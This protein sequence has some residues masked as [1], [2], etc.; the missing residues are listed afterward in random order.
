[1]RT[2]SAK[3]APPKGYV[4]ITEGRVRSSDMVWGPDSGWGHPTPTDYE[5]LGSDVIFYYAVARRTAR[6]GR[7]KCR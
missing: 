3:D 1:M 4:I 7:G 2:S 6:K 5:C